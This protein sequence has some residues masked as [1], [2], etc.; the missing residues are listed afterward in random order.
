MTIKEWMKLSARQRQKEGYLRNY[1]VKSSDIQWAT[2]RGGN[3]VARIFLSDAQLD[4]AAQDAK[5]RGISL[6]VLDPIMGEVALGPEW[7]KEGISGEKPSK[8]LCPICH[9]ALK[10][11]YCMEHGDIRAQGW[12]WDNKRKKWISPTR[13]KKGGKRK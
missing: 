5:K 3:R 8:T 4:A 12:R 6:D 1:P 9:R 13:S 10:N 11:G 2:V 7:Y